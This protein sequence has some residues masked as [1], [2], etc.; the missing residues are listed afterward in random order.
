MTRRT[1]LTQLGAFSLAT[2]H[3]PALTKEGLLISCSPRRRRGHCRSLAPA[4]ACPP[5]L[6]TAN[7]TRLRLEFAVTDSKQTIE[8]I[9]NRTKSACL[10]ATNHGSPVADRALRITNRELSNRP[11]G[12]LEIAATHSKQTTGPISNRPACIYPPPPRPFTTVPKPY[13]RTVAPFHP[14]KLGYPHGD[15]P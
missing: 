7:R 15:T 10:W 2:R 14:H 4:A 13:F 5:P 9:P 6:R 1:S 3:S 8:T 11:P 12:R